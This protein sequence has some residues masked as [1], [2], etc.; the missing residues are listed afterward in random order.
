MSKHNAHLAQSVVTA[1]SVQQLV[2]CLSDFDPQVKES[3]AWAIACIAKHS[4]KLSLDLIKEHAVAP[5]VVC[6]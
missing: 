5:L 1:G 6:I 4:E 3:A 2:A